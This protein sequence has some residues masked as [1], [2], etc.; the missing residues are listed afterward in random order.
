MPALL[1]AIAG[2]VGL[3]QV[4]SK[5]YWP[6]SYVGNIGADFKAWRSLMTFAFACRHLGRGMG[7]SAAALFLLVSGQSPSF[8]QTFNN[9]TVNGV[10][11]DHCESWGTNC[12]QGGA[13]LFCRTQGYQGAI[14]FQ[15]VNPG[16]TYNIGSQQVC[17]GGNCVA[18]SQVVC[19]GGSTTGQTQT[20]NTP[21][22]GGAAVDQCETWA[23]NCG[24]GGADQFCR[25]QGYSR[26]VG[27]TP[28]NPGRTYVI[29]SQ[30]I[31]EGGN[32]VGLAQV[33]CASEQ[34]TTAGGTFNYPQVNGVAVDNCETWA[35]NCGKGGADAF[36]RTQ[37]YGGAD[38]FQVFNPGRTWVI[39]N[40]QA[41][42]GG[43][44]VGFSQV[45]CG[46]GM[47]PPPPAG[48]QLT[49]M[50]KGAYPDYQFKQSG[51]T[52]TWYAA[53]GNETAQGRFLKPDRLAVTWFYSGGGS[54]STEGTIS[55]RDAYGRATQITW[56]NG[57]VFVRVN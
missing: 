34:P 40:Q 43:A 16:R 24:Q 10:M 25:T 15:V 48:D 52:F 3:S 31:C 23:T 7:L 12:G 37:G 54:G 47:P 57:Q 28:Y 22:A 1:L 41:C 11:V 44:C 56:D 46:A 19:S 8:A 27:F 20:F 26:A 55:A 53:S 35:T 33:V 51:D 2:G 30:Q 5:L 38:S 4:N 14:S 49:G 21:Q 45:V 9:P 29:G 13:N 17:E 39:G 18:F 32:C 36:C 50:W 6:L 42:E